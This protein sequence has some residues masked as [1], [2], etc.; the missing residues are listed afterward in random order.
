MER[1]KRRKLPNRV[2]HAVVDHAGLAERLASVDDSVSDRV[3]AVAVV[4]DPGFRKTSSNLLERGRVVRNAIRLPNALSR[5]ADEKLRPGHV[6]DLKLERR[7]SRVEDQDLHE[8][9]SLDCA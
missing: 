4:L 8:P 6:E 7:A 1:R 2:D 3:E 9:F 5:A